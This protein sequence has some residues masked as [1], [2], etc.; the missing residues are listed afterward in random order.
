MVE[1]EG[2][3]QVVKPFLL[4]RINQS[5]PDPSQFKSREEW[6]YAAMVASVYKK[7]GVELIGWLDSQVEQAKFL[8]KKKE[9]GVKDAFRIGKE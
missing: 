7:V 1:A 3:Q 9:E 2:Y 5:F 6:D 8:Q 4:E